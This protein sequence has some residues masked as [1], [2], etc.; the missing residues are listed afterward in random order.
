MSVKRGKYA[1]NRQGK[2]A[3]EYLAWLAMSDR[4]SD[5]FQIANP[6]YKGCYMSEEFKD[7][8]TFVDWCHT[9]PGFSFPDAQLDKDLLVTGNKL[10]GSETCVFLP[11]KVN[12]VINKR[13]ASRGNLPIGVSKVASNTKPYLAQCN[14]GASRFRQGFAT[15]E[16]A[17][18]AYKQE[19]ERYIKYLAKLYEGKIDQRAINA[20]LTYKVNI[21]D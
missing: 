21:N 8:D 2:Y 5:K 6:T 20:L 1:R 12:Q 17:F 18:L 10:Y 4:C 9:Q 11:R 19:K 14:R 7:F 16:D 13:A 3:K 15:V